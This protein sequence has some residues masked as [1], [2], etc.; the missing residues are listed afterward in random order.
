MVKFY[1]FDQKTTGTQFLRNF[2]Q[3]QSKITRFAGKWASLLVLMYCISPITGAAQSSIF[4]LI[5][6]P[7]YAHAGPGI[8]TLDKVAVSVRSGNL[9]PFKSWLA[10][11]PGIQVREYK[12][13]PPQG[14][15]TV[16]YVTDTSVQK[17]GYGLEVSDKSIKITASSEAGFMYAEETLIQLAEQNSGMFIPCVFINDYPRFAWRGMHLDESR[18]FMGKAFVKDYIDWLY[19]L[20]MNVFH[21][22]LT[23]AQGWRIEI[24]KYPKLTSIGAWRPDRSGLLF[25]E[26]DTAKVGEKMSYGGFYTQQEI[27]E[28][29]KYAADRNITIIPEIEMPGHSTAAL[30]A[31][32]EYS[33][34][35]GPFAMPGGAKNCPYPNYCIG[36]PKTIRFLEDVLTEVMN[37]FP[38]QYIHI[39]GDEVER[40]QW[41]NCVKCQHLKDSLLLRD[42]AQ[43]QVYLTS[44]IEK[45]LNS[46]GRRLMGWDE[47]MEGGGLSETAGVMVWR[48]E[49]QARKAVAE[50][51]NAVITYNYYF[52]LYQGSPALEPVTYGYLPL[53]Q[54]YTYEPA[55]KNMPE[56]Q[57]KKILGVEGCLWT[58]QIYDR[59]KAE[60]MLFPRLFALAESGWIG[61]DQRNWGGFIQKIPWA[62]EWLKKKNIHFATSVFDPEPVLTADTVQH[63]MK[64]TI[65]QQ[66]PFW[67]LYYT[68]EQNGKVTDT[69]PYNG[70]FALFDSTIVKTWAV[71]GPEQKSKVAML[72]F[73]PSLAT[74]KPMTLLFQ[75]DGRYNGSRPETLT[76][77]LTGNEAF[78]DGRW[79]GFYGDDFDLTIDLQQAKAI[80]KVSINWL[81]AEQSWIYLPDSMEV[82]VSMDGH[83]W[84]IAATKSEAEIDQIAPGNIKHVAIGM[85]GQATRYVRIKG[86]NKGQH[87]EL[88]AE[89]C[90]LFVDEVRVD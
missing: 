36:N 80:T 32:P 24:K 87:P 28:I 38:S 52:D 5:P 88:P 55:P 14:F 65:R 57:Q 73:C 60:Y 44:E 75:P 54:V 29:V 89:K 4:K 26:A 2:K 79:C 11:N 39:G 62:M 17:E 9:F 46:H 15:K 68:L 47:I 33:C 22:H 27:K 53:D 23:D 21:W 49:D 63:V 70:T 59:Q 48:G 1:N 90:W 37:L 42:E 78:H 25:N 45:F 61:A 66:I 6:E 31:Y 85:Q 72:N 19:S 77:G 13:T 35:G 86:K 3:N 8:F 56:D 74:A 83:D 64:C 50:G 69:L 16:T 82:S 81:K 41:K 30:V 18:H 40:D 76:D 7:K 67:K 84:T 71:N 10:S 34:T 43:L 20:K 58:E 12:S 51:R